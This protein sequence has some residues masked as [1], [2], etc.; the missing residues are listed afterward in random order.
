MRLNLNLNKHYDGL[1]LENVNEIFSRML[2]MKPNIDG[3]SFLYDESEER[4]EKTDRWR[5]AKAIG[6]ATLHYQVVSLDEYMT[7]L[8]KESIFGTTKEKEFTDADFRA[9]IEKYNFLMSE[10]EKEQDEKENKSVDDTENSG[11]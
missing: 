4:F 3:L 11:R 7:A 5:N 9:I 2:D 8:E 6:E 1:E 10:P